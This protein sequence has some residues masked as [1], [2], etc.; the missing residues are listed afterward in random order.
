MESP[1]SLWAAPASAHLFSETFFSI[2][3]PQSTPSI[4]Q[5]FWASFFLHF[6]LPQYQP[7]GAAAAQAG[8]EAWGPPAEEQQ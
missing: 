1:Q 7:A 2:H 4:P 3:S 8:H 5:G 6:L